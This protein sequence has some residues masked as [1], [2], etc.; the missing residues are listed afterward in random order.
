M[1]V[2][3]YLKVIKTGRLYRFLRWHYHAFGI[4]TLP[5][6]LFRFL[7]NK[8]F[9]KVNVGNEFSVFLR[10]GTTDMDVY[11]EIFIKKELD[12]EI[13]EP[14][15]IVDAGSHT[16]FSSIW[17][18]R[19]YPDAKIL[20]IEPEESNFNLLKINT[21]N[22]PNIICI[23][24]GLWNEQTT[25]EIEN[26]NVD[27]WKFTVK[28]SGR[29]TIPG[30]DG[31]SIPILMKKNNWNRIDLLKI[32]IE[33]SEVEVF[34]DSNQ[35]INSVKVIIIELHDRVRSGCREALVK[36]TC[37]FEIINQTCGEKIILRN[38][39]MRPLSFSFNEN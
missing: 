30:V 16:G 32:D 5:F 26:M 15:Y 22:Y 29:N 4:A 6:C 9:V 36:A 13:S 27:N 25:L 18:S 24:A 37:N 20:A 31:V 28:K 38:L 39:S 2:L 7:I 19:R 14:E 21:R 1:A 23:N 3:R 10:A 8:E 34:N 12:F 17:F 33:G 11:N 35:W